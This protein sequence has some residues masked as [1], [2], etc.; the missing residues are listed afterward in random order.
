MVPH[1]QQVDVT[2]PGMTNEDLVSGFGMVQS[3]LQLT[4]A[5]EAA[6][7]WLFAARLKSG[8][9]RSSFGRRRPFHSSPEP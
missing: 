3:R 7:S 8:P 6:F 1:D 2:S 5:A 9:S 4:S